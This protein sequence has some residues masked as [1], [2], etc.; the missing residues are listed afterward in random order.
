MDDN[1]SNA[2]QPSRIITRRSALALPA[3][4]G[5]VGAAGA[6]SLAP[7]VAS[8]EPRL[9]AVFPGFTA[10]DLN[11]GAHS[12]REFTGRKRFVV[13]IT[14]TDAS[15]LSR[16]WLDQAE[17]RLG[18]ARGNVHT[19][20]A[21]DLSFIAFDSIVRSQARA[22]TPQHRWPF[23]WLERDGSLA[24]AVGLP[25]GNRTPW[26]YVIDAQG[27]V[28]MWIHGTVSHP[29]AAAFWAMLVS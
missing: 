22:H 24:R 29:D 4:I 27:V 20:V 6:A 16:A 10:H 21:L 26:A 17:A 28:R 15:E 13:A 14:S 7:R 8:A 5:A 1:D 23:V 18:R 2:T 11:G 12:N 19:L 9:G 25:N 3:A